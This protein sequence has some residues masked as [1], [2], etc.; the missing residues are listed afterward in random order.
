M[1]HQT[2]PFSHVVINLYKDVVFAMNFKSTSFKTDEQK[3]DTD[4]GRSSINGEKEIIERMLIAP[5][6]LRVTRCTDDKLKTM[7]KSK[8]SKV[9]AIGFEGERLNHNND[10]IKSDTN[11]SRLKVASRKNVILKKRNL[12][13]RNTIELSHFAGDW[14]PYSNLSKSK[15]MDC[16]GK[17][18]T[19]STSQMDSIGTSM[20][21]KRTNIYCDFRKI[22]FN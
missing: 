18:K 8:A 14:Q 11:E 9:D 17:M 21:G 15:L 4:S 19:K 6:S 10:G 22:L 1:Y 5:N 12:L 13:R 2:K 16:D 3:S 20:P 7:L